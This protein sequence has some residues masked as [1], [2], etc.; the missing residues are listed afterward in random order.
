M[1]EPVTD[2]RWAPP[3]PP[4]ARRP[5]TRAAIVDAAV[6]LADA[7]G[8]EAVSMPRLARTLDAAP[9]SLYRHVPH[10]D[11]LV[12]LMLD[13]AIGDPPPSAGPWRDALTAWARGN[14]AVF[15]DHPWTLPLVSGP[16]RMGPAECA[17]G[18][19]ALRIGVDAGFPLTEAIAVV[20]LVNSYVRG[21]SVPLDDRAPS[22]SD[23]H[24]SGRAGEFPLFLSLLEATVDEPPD[25]AA[26]MFD[27]GLARIL[28]GV[29]RHRDALTR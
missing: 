26:R 16:R 28:D 23:L 15:R 1:P 7:E 8:L 9:M 10:K 27:D 19:A 5:L 24:A 17:W 13:A 21:A 29:E 25:A 4:T 22:V 11:A 3:P 20:H 18:E 12:D 14:R 6:A 2:P